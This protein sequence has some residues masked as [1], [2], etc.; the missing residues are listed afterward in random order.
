MANIKTEATLKFNY[1]VRDPSKAGVDKKRPDWMPSKAFD[2]VS[3]PFEAS[4]A[5]FTKELQL[6]ES[7]QDWDGIEIRFS[8]PKDGKD[9]VVCSGTI[10]RVETIYDD[11]A[12]EY[13]HIA[14]IE[15]PQYVLD[16][17]SE[18]EAKTNLA[19]FIEAVFTNHGWNAAPDI[20]PIH[21][22]ATQDNHEII[23]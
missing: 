4:Y 21:Y 17:S 11:K 2:V 22:D 3:K 7:Y 20:A 16:A 23:N 5:I 6:S 1:V 8:K 15:I 18:E 12:D 14:F 10:H 9:V 13:K 19:A